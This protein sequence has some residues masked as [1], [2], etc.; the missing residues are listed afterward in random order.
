MWMRQNPLPTILLQGPGP[1]ADDE[2]R[3][4]LQDMPLPPH[5]Y[6]VFEN[7]LYTVPAEGLFVASNRPRR[8]QAFERWDLVQEFMKRGKSLGQ[9]Q[10]SA[11]LL[12]G[13]R[14]TGKTFSVP[15]AQVEAISQLE[16][17]EGTPAPRCS[18]VL[19]RTLQLEPH[20]MQGILA[21]QQYM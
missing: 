8:P 17:G 12:Y 1:E 2:M 19:V 15:W 6:S 7:Y 4:L 5:I 10:V 21:P 18:H 20:G 14:R 13:L 9:V 3:R 11:L 16:G